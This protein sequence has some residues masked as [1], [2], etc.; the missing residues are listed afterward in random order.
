MTRMTPW[1]LV[2]HIPVYISKKKHSDK[3]IEDGE[4]MSH[5][6]QGL[7]AHQNTVSNSNNKNNQFTRMIPWFFRQP[8]NGQKTFTPNGQNDSFFRRVITPLNKS[9]EDLKIQMEKVLS[10][11][12]PALTTQDS[13][14]TSELQLLNLPTG[15]YQP[16]LSDMSSPTPHQYTPSPPQ[17]PQHDITPL[18]PPSN[19]QDLFMLLSLEKR[20]SDKL[21]E[22]S[23]EL[24]IRVKELETILSEYFIDTAYIDSLRHRKKSFFIEGGSED[25]DNT[26]ASSKNVE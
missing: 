2:H 7:T 19:N 16:N 8:L 14:S 9:E 20:R 17:L 24:S 25:G 4:F 22:R 11:Q 6:Q 10:V 5:E 12:Q 18:N 15:F 23:N 21:E 1:G 3:Y 26:I 13:R